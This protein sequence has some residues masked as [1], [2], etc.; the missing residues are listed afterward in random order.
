MEYIQETTFSHVSK[1]FG[2]EGDA[3]LYVGKAFE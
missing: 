1:L 2:K 3:C